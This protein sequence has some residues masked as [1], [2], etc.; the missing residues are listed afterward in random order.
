MN[1]AS[2]GRLRLDSPVQFLKG[3]GPKRAPLL[4]RLGI[5]RVE[6]LLYHIPYDYLMHGGVVPLGKMREGIRATT[7]GRLLDLQSRRIRGGRTLVSG[8]I[9]D[10]PAR[11]ALSWF[12]APW[13]TKQFT[14]GEE[15]VVSGEPTRYRGRLQMVNPAFETG[16][17][18]GELRE[19]RPMPR[20]ALTAGIAQAGLRGLVRRA[21]DA[22]GEQLVDPMPEQWRREE[23]LPTLREAL[24][25]VHRPADLEQAEGGRRRLAFDEALA[26]QLAVGVRRRHLLRRAASVRVTQLGDLSRHYVEGLGFE[27]TGAQRRVLKDLKEDLASEW[28]MHRLLQGDVGSGKTLVAL[29][30]MIWS[31][32]A[33]GQAAFM[34]PTEI[35]ARQ[36]AAKHLPELEALGL[37]GAVLTGSTPAAERRAIL[38][39]LRDATLQI[40]FGTHALIQAD[41]EFARLGLAVVDEQHRFGVAQRASLSGGGAHLLVMSATPIPRS[42]ALTVFA[43]LDLSILDEKPPGRMPVLTHIVNEEALDEL[44]PRLRRRIEDGGRAYLV[45]PLVQESEEGTS[46]ARRRATRSWRRVPWRVWTWVFCTDA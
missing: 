24:E 37:R 33:G 19:G 17:G 44:Y 32:E 25:A 6:D 4:A 9:G 23:A 3:A 30:A 11:L 45:F 8:V 2:A 29:V 7:R 40:V 21:L 12:N 46:Q 14:V 39:G 38:R 28:A 35:L 18:D 1:S 16:E 20:Y 36:H 34:A 31:V 27:L 15:I 42:L 43:D 10:G 5:E 41:I 13:V 22:V 26:L